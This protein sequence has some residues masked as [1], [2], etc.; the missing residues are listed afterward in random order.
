[1][2]DAAHPR[3][4]S[5]PPEPIRPAA[6]DLVD[7]VASLLEADPDQREALLA[8]L[9]GPEAELARARLTALGVL[10]LSLD[11]PAPVLGL[12]RRLGRF[13]RLERVGAGGMGEV[14]LARDER[15]GELAAIKLLRPEHLWFEAAH[16]RFRRELEALAPLAHRGIVRVLEVGEEHGVPWLA[17]EWV[18]GASLELVVDRLR[19]LPPDTLESSDFEEAVHDACAGRPHS[20]PARPGAFP[21][22]TYVEVVAGVVARVAEA[23]AHAHAAGV[24]HRDVKPSNV[25]VTPSGRVLLADFGLA[26]PR[27]VDRITRAGSWLGSLPYAAPEQIEG[28]ARAIDGRA[29]VYG[30]GALMYELL[31]LRTPFLG[32][33][34]QQIRRRIATGDLASPRSLNRRIPAAVE[35]VCLAAVDPDAERRPAG[36]RELAQD[37]ERALAGRPVHSRAPSVPLRARRWIRRHPARTAALVSVALVA[38]LLLGFAVRE[39]ATARRMAR[40]LDAELVRG[41]IDET[42]AFWPAQPA[43]IAPMD[44]W[45]ARA[46]VVLDRRAIHE[47]ELAALMEH[48]LPPTAEDRLRTQA[49]SLDRLA[50][51]LR[52]M[53]GL[54]SYVERSGQGVQPEPPDPTRVRTRDREIEALIA[55][56]TEQAASSVRARIAEL[57]ASARLAPERWQRDIA[58]IDQF[59]VSAERWIRA[60]E[61]PP[62][63]RFAEGLDAWRYRALR[64]LLLDC[65]RL[66]PLT[67]RVEHQLAE[68]RRLESLAASATVDTWRQATAAIAASPHYAGL[69]LEPVFGLVPLGA[70]PRSGLWEFLLAS[71]GDAPLRDPDGSGRWRIE[72]ESGLVLVLLPG[73]RFRMGQPTDE[74]RVRSEARPVHTVELDPFL[75]SEFEMTR[76]QAE[77]MGHVMTLPVRT[78]DARLPFSADWYSA[79][80]LLHEQGLELPTEAQWEYAARA[81]TEPPWPLEGQAN[82]C[83]LALQRAWRLQG[84]TSAYASPAPFDDGWVDAAPVGSFRANAFGLHDMLGNVAEWC[85]DPFVFRGYSS[86]VARS[87]DGLRDCVAEEGAKVV[88]GGSFVDSPVDAQPWMRHREAPGTLI[89]ALGVRPVMRIVGR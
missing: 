74:S 48:A 9:P 50:A 59:E 57:R 82:V 3:S 60:L 13:V 11:E 14:H 34:E 28:E 18:G 4:D 8:R 87:G 44:S 6:D 42:D 12:P 7:I 81:D 29:D 27:G 78:E 52:E 80:E 41:L 54:Q 22:R 55:Q 21:G 10:G 23:L 36:A 76:G 40:L 58:Q 71:S 38:A 67:M 45:L 2:S 43:Q 70:D 77:R 53:D 33:P 19:G 86:L 49:E 56:T 5:A 62:T 85:L 84:F 64:R 46:R 72:A 61:D 75:V 35:A 73:G 68:T 88:R 39:V 66:A 89:T 25:L 16:Q 79:R 20:E 51:L 83:D 65:D 32:G 24:L 63:T 69:R 31:T 47:A 26:L 1:M 30:L 17:L 15:T 37:L